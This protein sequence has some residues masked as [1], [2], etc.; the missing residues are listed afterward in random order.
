MDNVTAMEWA[1]VIVVNYNSSRKWEIVKESL[2]SVFSLK[3]RPL[4]VIIV[5][6]G[7][8]DGSYERI[9]DLVSSL[10]KDPL[11]RVRL[12]RLSK[13]YGFAVANDIAY[14]MRSPES[15]YVA[16]INN[17]LAPEP[18]SLGTLI[19]LLQKHPRMAG[20]QGVILSWDGR[21]IDGYGGYAT[22]HG[23]FYN[24][25]ASL[26]SRFA[27]G[28]RP[29][30]VTYLLGSYSVF[31]VK[32]IEDSCGLFHPYFFMW[33]DDTEVGIRLWRSGW[34]LAAV[35]VIAGR[36][37]GS[38]TVLGDKT[39]S[40]LESPSV[41]Y[42]YKY[43]FMTSNIA[44]TVTYFQP[45]ILR[46]MQRLPAL[47]G[48]ILLKRNFAIV[49]GL[50]DGVRLGLKLRRKLPGLSRKTG[51]PII[52]VKILRELTLLAKL[53]ILHGKKANRI[54]SIALSRALGTRSLKKR[55]ARSMP[56]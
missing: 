46:V 30:P 6:N 47:F 37:Y 33:G 53:Y 10:P 31:R 40:P 39:V 50:I 56:L 17:D 38:A 22:Q 20:V 54:Y 19:G 2:M 13:N 18:N 8:N 9:K 4:E 25:G 32:A 11:F 48:A 49:R 12:I 26:E 24:V 45:W 27:L 36:H 23:V 44:V 1:T 55:N 3:Y 28:F 21:Y 34:F 29:I 52:K 16:L 15:K 41:P 7:S 14:L 51:E 35:P 43:W 5:D 42:V